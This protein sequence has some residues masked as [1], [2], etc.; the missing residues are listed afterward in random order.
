VKK[1]EIWPKKSKKIEEKMASGMAGAKSSGV[2]AS[3]CAPFFPPFSCFFYYETAVFYPCFDRKMRR[4][5]HFFMV[6]NGFFW[7]ILRVFL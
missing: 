3:V 4:F 6:G 7:L 1:H 5:L 2:A